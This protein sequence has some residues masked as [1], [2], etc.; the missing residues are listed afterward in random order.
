MAKILI[1]DDEERVRTILR[2]MLAAKG[3]AIGEAGNGLE[4]LE[5]LTAHTYDLVI[6]D[7]R[8]DGLDGH[9]LLKAIKEQNLGCPVVFITAFATLESAVEAL[10]LGAA[11]YLVKPFEEQQV[12]L[13]VERALGI[14]RLL[15]ENVHL[16]REIK[17]KNL[18]DEEGVFL[19]AAMKKARELALQ[20]A[21]GNTTVLITGESGT[22]KEI[23]AK[24]IHQASERREQRF[25]TLNCAA[26]SPNLVESELFGHE[27]GAFTSAGNRKEGKFEFARGGT[28]FLD[29]IGELPLEAQVK[30]LRVVQERVVQRVGG[31]QDIEVDIRLICATNQDLARLVENSRFRRDLYYRIAVFP[32][33]VPPLRER[34]EAMGALAT[35]FI[36]HWE[37]L[38]QGTTDFITPGA[39]QV[40]KNYPWPGNVREL[41]NAMERVMILKAGQL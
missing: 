18:A 8:M 16:R 10:R 1:V 31:N 30:L 36:H 34:Q 22:G 9:G 25:V 24:L 6:S 20:V 41:A 27:K 35:F 3:H 40:L 26:I 11:D 21:P 14:G 19:S 33:Q 38:R 7:I 12:H 17:Q 37:G 23:V 13:A 29:E 32:I 5:Q 15:A 2:L 28:L 39:L 4:A